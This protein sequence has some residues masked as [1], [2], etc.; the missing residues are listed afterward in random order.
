[1][2]AEKLEQ[3]QIFRAVVEAQA[4][5]TSSFY[6][7]QSNL[8]ILNRYVRNVPPSGK[9]ALGWTGLLLLNFVA[10]TGVIPE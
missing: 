1:M 4:N 3:V 6:F 7:S 8:F 10:W 5:E 2:P 9:P